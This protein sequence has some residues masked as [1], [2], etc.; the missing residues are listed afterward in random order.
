[1]P[2]TGTYIDI[3]FASSGS[4]TAVP[5]AVQGDGSVSFTQGYG[6]NY[7]LPQGSPGALNVENVK[8]NYLF[9][10]LTTTT[11]NWQQFTTASWITHAENGGSAFSYAKYALVLYTDGHVY[12]SLVGS[13]TTDPVND[14]INWTI[15]DS[16]NQ[17]ITLGSDK[18]FYISTTGND[19]TGNGTSGTP[20]A[21]LNKA[22]TTLANSYD[23]NGNTATIQMADGTYT[24]LNVTLPI[25]GFVIING[26]SVT[27]TNVVVSGG[28]SS[29]I[30]VYGTN[31]PTN[32][33]VQNFQVLSTSQNGLFAENWGYIK[34]GVG[35]VFGT[36]GIA[37]IA[38]DGTSQITVANGYTISG[39]AAY[40]WYCIYQ[41]IIYINGKTITLTGT[42]AFSTA[43]AFSSECSTIDCASITFSG[44]AT[45]SRYSASTNGVIT[46][47]G[48]G[49]TYLPG[50]SSGTTST[51]GQYV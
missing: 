41:S 46:T 30:A 25:N 21:T 35:M 27:P 48:G 26:N 38:S 50:N 6:P 42:P 36:C 28:S 18:T 22:W 29:A 13:N 16:S 37:H 10:L 49:S 33:T 39:N 11:Q 4:V 14:G 34:I 40:H 45:G 43:F 3:P 20:W 32:I 31:G 5:D 24:G 51:G 17:R 47:S 19:T 2:I 23:L 44:S 1:M 7:E 15:V 12:E 9:N 8:M